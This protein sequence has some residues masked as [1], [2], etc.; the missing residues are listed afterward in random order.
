MDSDLAQQAVSASL[1]LD[2][3]KAVLLNSQ[4]IKNNPEDIDALNRIARAYAEVGNLTKAKIASQKVLK[5]D[6]L[7][8]IAT[9]CLLKWKNFKAGNGKT[10]LRTIALPSVF[11]E[12]PNKTK[13]VNLFYLGDSI[14]LANLTCGDL[15]KLVPHMHRLNVVTYDDKLIGR[16]PDDLASK[17]IK[18]MK[19]GNSYDALIR[20]THE[21][22][23][24]IFVRSTN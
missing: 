6:R 14:N 12:E 19:N 15:V 21:K 24:K 23:V 1:T 22:Q 2:W 20:S 9:K 16:F 17:F 10:N 3:E 11:I 8:P 18:L 13:T 5:I 4:I 7:N